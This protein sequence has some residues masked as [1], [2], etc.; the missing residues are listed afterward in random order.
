[1][2]GV[3]NRRLYEIGQNIRQVRLDRGMSQTDLALAV[4]TN[5]NAVS[6]WESGDRVIRLDSLIGIADALEVPVNE[7]LITKDQ[8]G[9]EWDEFR[10]ESWQLSEDE[11][12]FLLRTVR[13]LIQ[14]IHSGIR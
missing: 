3:F 5:K 2:A 7:L 10:K 4:D 9:D 13:T 12:E 1:M 14:G 11:R 8:G 6:R